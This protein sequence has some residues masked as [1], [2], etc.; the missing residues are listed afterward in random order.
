MASVT[1]SFS[2]DP[3]RDADVVAW[4]DNLPTYRGALSEAILRAI[5][6][7]IRTRQ[8][9]HS[10]GDALE[11]VLDK[12]NRIEGRIQTGGH[13]EGEPEAQDTDLPPDILG[14]LDELA[15]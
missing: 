7:E 12:L 4:I 3:Q 2:L 1:K 13:I 14:A 9:G 10:I 11:L 15:G 5:R 6:R 8:G